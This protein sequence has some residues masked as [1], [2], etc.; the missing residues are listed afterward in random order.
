[1]TWDIAEP[2]IT[3]N[4]GPDLNVIK[5]RLTWDQLLAEAM[6]VERMNEL[7]WRPSPRQVA[8][9]WTDKLL[10]VIPASVMEQVAPD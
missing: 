2:K 6:K 10:H 8:W 3:P 1:M 4:E 5:L 7:E 9:T